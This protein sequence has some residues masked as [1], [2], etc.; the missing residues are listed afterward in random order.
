MENLTV[1]VTT[2]YASV[3]ISMGGVE[4]KTSGKDMATVLRNMPLEDVAIFAQFCET[5]LGTLADADRLILA[6][7]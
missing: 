4:R 1:F 3:G 2:T 5:V 7:K 6:S